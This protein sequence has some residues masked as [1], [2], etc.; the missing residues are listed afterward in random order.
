[1]VWSR[2]LTLSA[3]VNGIANS[4]ISLIVDQLFKGMYS[5][6]SDDQ[7]TVTNSFSEFKMAVTDM[8]NSLSSYMTTIQNGPQR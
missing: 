6:I 1:M 3:F 2:Q 4:T 7:S 8:Q 5:I